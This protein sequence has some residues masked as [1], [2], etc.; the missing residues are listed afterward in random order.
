MN[1]FTKE[2]IFKFKQPQ[3]FPSRI[4]DNECLNYKDLIFED[5][6]QNTSESPIYTNCEFINIK[7]FADCFIIE[8]NE[9]KDFE[10]LSNIK[11]NKNLLNKNI[12]NSAKKTQKMSCNGF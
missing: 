8:D 6:L 3:I 5:N 12:E 2:F 10:A 7:N 4:V 1:Q 11:K 9:N